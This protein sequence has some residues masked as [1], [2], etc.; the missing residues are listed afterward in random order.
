MTK[1]VEVPPRPEQVLDD[2]RIQYQAMSDLSDETYRQLAADI[3][4]LG[5]LEPIITDEAGT[6]IDGHHRAAIVE[7]YDLPESKCPA[8]VTLADLDDES[9]LARAIKQ[10]L[11]GRDITDAVKQRAAKQYI[12]T[13]W[14][15][16]DEGDLIRPETNKEVAEKLGVGKSTVARVFDSSAKGPTLEVVKNSQVG[17]IYHD[18]V[19]AREYYED[20][21]D[22]SYREVARQ[23]DAS[24]PTVTE[25]LK[26]DFDEGDTG[27]DGD[28]TPLTA[29]ARNEDEH[30]KTQDVAQKATSEDVDDDIQQEAQEQAEKLSRGETSPQTASKNVEKAEAEDAVEDQRD[31][32]T[33]QPTVHQADALSFIGSVDETVDLL[34]TDPPYSTDLDDVGAFARSW[35]PEA[36]KLV[37]SDGFAFIFVG[38]YPD[39]LQ[40]YLNVIGHATPWSVCQVLVWTYRNTLGRAPNDRYKLNWQAILFLRGP[41]APDLDTPKTSEQWAVQDVNAPDGRFGERHHKWEK[42]TEIADRF[43]RHTTAE[44]DTVLDPFAGTGTFALTAAELGRDV[45]ACDCD[46]NMLEIASERGCLIDE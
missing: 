29:F 5:V 37:A 9:K 28:T 43:I 40:S 11:L 10:N 2:D 1:S 8:Y 6:I 33:A 15:R 36:L 16:T 41:E 38:A 12:T 46:S 32:D 30:E 17:V 7:Y 13:A 22:A 25:W 45:L 3:R 23:V 35:V 18:R 4:N 26:E 44:D 19:K 27:D 39:E 14:E 21:P 31:T 42:P 20:N 34:M 24:R